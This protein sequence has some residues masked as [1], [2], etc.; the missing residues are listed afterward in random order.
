MDDGGWI[1]LHRKV[2][3]SDLWR[4]LR[5]DQRGVFVTLLLLANWAPRKARWGEHWYVV[6]RGELSH[7]L[8]TIAREAGASVKVVRSTVA[9]LRSDGAVSEKYPIS[10]TGPGTGPRV[11]TIVNYDKY[12]DVSGADGTGPG[13]D[14]AR[15]GHGSGTE[16]TKGTIETIS[17]VGERFE[18]KAWGQAKAALRARLR[19]DLFSRWFAPLVA[20]ASGG[21]LVLRAPSV[22]HA[23]F[24]SDNWESLLSEEL[25]RAGLEEPFRLEPST[26]QR[27]ATA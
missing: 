15:V 14:R 22:H 20:D 27:E 11:L 9:A 23:R 6:G 21:G 3:G 7:T 19:A 26:T 4:S 5:A 18:E 10:G 2:R 12:Q 16:R 13:T 25:A 8:Q 1:T 17:S 24:I